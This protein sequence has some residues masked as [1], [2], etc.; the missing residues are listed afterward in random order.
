VAGALINAGQN[1]TAATRAYVQRP[2][3]EA[4][5]ERV[6]SLMGGVRLGPV[7]DPATDMGS[8]ISFR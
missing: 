4:F 7:D 1:C 6:A 8:L 2:L 5:V 3:Y